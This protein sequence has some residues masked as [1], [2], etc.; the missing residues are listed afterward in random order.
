MISPEHCDGF[1]ESKGKGLY[2]LLQ[3][4]GRGGEGVRTLSSNIDTTSI[5]H[6]SANSIGTVLA[7][8]FAVFVVMTAVALNYANYVDKF[9]DSCNEL[10]TMVLI[11]TICRVPVAAMMGYVSYTYVGKKA[12]GC[13]DTFWNMMLHTTLAVPFLVLCCYEGIYIHKAL[14]DSVCQALM[15]DA[16]FRT[17]FLAEIG[18]AWL[19]IDCCI[20]FS[21]VINYCNYTF[22]WLCC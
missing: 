5:A 16:G 2:R 13:T 14:E 6:V 1:T 11:A 8:C 22:R 12:C 7:L 17:L 20:A 19:I 21:F 18:I 10:W 3:T 15:Q 9:R 4:A